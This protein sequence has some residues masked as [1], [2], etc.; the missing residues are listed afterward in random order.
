V[1]ASGG[2][3]SSCPPHEVDISSGYGFDHSDGPSRFTRYTL[4]LLAVSVVCCLIFTPFL[5]KD[6]AQCEEWRLAGERRGLSRSIGVAAVVLSLLTVAYGFLAAVL[7]LD[8]DT[9]C[10]AFVGGTGCS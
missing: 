3:A 7:L 8:P 10:L 6:K 2:G 9:S 1:R 5:P 4:V